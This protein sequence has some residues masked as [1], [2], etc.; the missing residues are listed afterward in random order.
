MTDCLCGCQAPLW[1]FPEDTAAHDTH[2]ENPLF[3]PAAG[4]QAA[5]P[6]AQAALPLWRRCL[7]A[8]QAPWKRRWD[9]A[10]R[11]LVI[12]CIL[13]IPCVGGAAV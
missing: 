4:P 5:V 11:L 13:I 10:M 1:R 7:V 2:T 6:T 3:E 8:P 9:A 12:Y